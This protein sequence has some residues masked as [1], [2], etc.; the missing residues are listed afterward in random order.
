MRKKARPD[1]AF[2][3]TKPRTS[4]NRR[5]VMAQ[6]CQSAESMRQTATVRRRPRKKT[7]ASAAGRGKGLLTINDPNW[8]RVSAAARTMSHRISARLANRRRARPRAVDEDVERAP[9]KASKVGGMAAAADRVAQH[10][11]VKLHHDMRGGPIFWRQC[12]R[13]S[14]P[15]VPAEPARRQG[16]HP[17]GLAR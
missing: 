14:A 1:S 9:L 6:S 17:W 3:T 5:G 8:V 16:S 2:R 11:V 12:R 15:R 10:D 4:V 13:S 7:R